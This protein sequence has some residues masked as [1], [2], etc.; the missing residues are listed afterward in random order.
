MMPRKYG[1]EASALSR[2][3]K[4]A[5]L[6]ATGRYDKL[7]QLD[8]AHGKNIDESYEREFGGDRTQKRKR[9]AA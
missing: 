5:A 8:E 7:K 6:A 2:D 4:L 1:D 3:E 9:K